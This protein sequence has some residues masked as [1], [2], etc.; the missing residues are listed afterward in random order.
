MIFN[1]VK[2]GLLKSFD[3]DGETATITNWDY[4]E[5]D[6]QPGVLTRVGIRGQ[7]TKTR[8]KARE[9]YQSLLDQGYEVID[10]LPSTLPLPTK[11]ER[12]E[13]VTDKFGK[14]TFNGVGIN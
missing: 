10:G 11:V 14:E 8:A 12:I 2:N 13:V 3:I 5:S 7:F 1:L 6:I 9:V 4:R